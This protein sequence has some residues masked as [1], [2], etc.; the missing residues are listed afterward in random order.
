[1][2]PQPKAMSFSLVRQ[3]TQAYILLDM[4]LQFRSGK[5]VIV[6]KNVFSINGKAIY[7]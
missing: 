2:C 3:T 7:L 5:S 1:M 4:Q 6:K